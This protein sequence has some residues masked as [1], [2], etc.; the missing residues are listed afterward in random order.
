ML[1][2]AAQIIWLQKEL[3]KKKTLS[4]GHTTDESETDPATRFGVADTGEISGSKFPVTTLIV[5]SSVS[6]SC[7]ADK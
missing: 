6:S 7:E 3:E 4:G 2:I 1:S 5:S